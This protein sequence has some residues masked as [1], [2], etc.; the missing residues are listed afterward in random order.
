MSLFKSA[1]NAVKKGLDRTREGFVAS[2][3]SLLRGRQLDDQLLIAL[4]KQMIEGDLGVRTTSRLM[5]ELREADRSRT[6]QSG[7]EVLDYLKR[8]L[9]SMWP[10]ADRKLA[11]SE[12]GTS[13]MLVTGVNGVGK[14]TSLAKLP[15]LMQRE[16]KTVLLG[17]CDT[18]RAGAVR[19]LEIWAERL[20]VDIVKGQQG[21]DPAAV[22]GDAAAAAVAALPRDGATATD[23]VEHLYGEFNAKN[24]LRVSTSALMRTQANTSTNI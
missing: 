6:I 23:S 17:A 12:T 13:V 2:L 18:F 10:P 16:G 1:I 5:A 15:R 11:L 22:A 8:E 20:G 7:D 9:S 3:R 14:T 24:P 19:Q 4:E 21:G